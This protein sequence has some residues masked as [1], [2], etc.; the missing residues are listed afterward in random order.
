MM[1]MLELAIHQ[2]Y[3]VEIIVPEWDPVVGALIYAIESSGIKLNE[4][5]TQN[6]INTFLKK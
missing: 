6:L 4:D 5:I 1:N 2:K 3:D